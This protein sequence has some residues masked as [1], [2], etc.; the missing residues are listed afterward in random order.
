MTLLKRTYDA[1]WGRLFARLYDRALAASE[2]GGLGA[3]RAELLAAARGHV[4]EIGAG[5]GVNL[6]YYTEAVT[7]LTLTEPFEPMARQLRERA[8]AL[9]GEAAV[10]VAPAE[11]LP[12]E[13][14]SIDTVVVTLV[15]CTVG[16]VGVTLAEI[17]RVLVPGGRL[18]FLEHVRSEDPA[19]AR[20]QDRLERPWRFIGHGCHPNRDTLAAIEAS[21]LEVV[22]VERGSVPKAAAFV[23]PMLAGSARRPG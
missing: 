12:V 7:E 16:D 11:R 21:P 17:E 8:D 10:I 15:L 13:D 22:E 19:L 18:L 5:T 23:R 20:W 4:L 6:P 2:H 14:A 1:S 9:G 3:R